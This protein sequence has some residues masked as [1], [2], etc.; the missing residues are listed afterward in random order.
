[1]YIYRVIF[2]IRNKDNFIKPAISS[3]MYRN[4]YVENLEFLHKRVSVIQPH[5]TMHFIFTESTL[6]LD[7]G[8]FNLIK[9]GSE[10]FC[11]TIN[12][13]YAVSCDGQESFRKQAIDLIQLPC[14]LWRVVFACTTHTL[15][16]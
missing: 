7:F 14:T 16:F 4:R 13:N 12:I 9:F 5:I 3:F 1:M 10:K 2:P 8:S 15:T 6:V 11:T